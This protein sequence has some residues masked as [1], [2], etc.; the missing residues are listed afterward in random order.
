MSA[1][2]KMRMIIE[3]SIKYGVQREFVKK[4]FCHYKYTHNVNRIKPCMIFV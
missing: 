4:L 3:S 2:V 1:V